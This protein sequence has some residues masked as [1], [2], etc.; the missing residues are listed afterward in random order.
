VRQVNRN[1]GGSCL[2]GDDCYLVG[3]AL[4]NSQPMKLL[5][6]SVE[7][8]VKASLSFSGCALKLTLLTVGL[9]NLH[10]IKPSDYRTFGLSIQNLPF[11]LILPLYF[12][13][14]HIL[15]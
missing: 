2:V 14:I 7:P 3:D 8:W 1:A 11:Y 13:H 6:W 5:M 9:L 4:A 10:I 12:V 15:K